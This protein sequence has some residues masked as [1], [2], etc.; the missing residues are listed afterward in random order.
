[1]RAVVLDADALTSFAEDPQ[2]LIAATRNRPAATLLTPHEGEFG[3]LFREITEKAASKLEKARKAAAETGAIILLK[4]PDTVV[5]APDGRAAIADN[6]PPWL[7]TAGSGDVLAGIAAGLL[8]QGMEGFEA[9]AA[10]VWLHGEAGSVAGPGLIAEDLPEMMPAVYRRLVA[11]AWSGGRG[12]ERRTPWGTPSRAARRVQLAEKRTPSSRDCR[13]RTQYARSARRRPGYRANKISSRRRA[14]RADG[15][16]G[17]ARAA[18]GV[19]QVDC[20]A[21]A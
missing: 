9:A 4:G 18:P 6:A 20:A 1:E 3:R 16:N 12:P 17:R 15:S 2:A 21:P 8:A 10:A 11:P 13:R 7:A 5:A 14:G 19:G